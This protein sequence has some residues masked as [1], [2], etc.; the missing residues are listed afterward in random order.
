VGHLMGLPVFTDANIPT[1]LGAGTNE[2]RIIVFA[3][4]V[5]HLWERDGDPVTLSFEQLAG[6]SLQVQLVCYGY[7]AFPAGR[8]RAAAGGVSAVTAPTLYP[9][10][11]VAGCARGAPP[12]HRRPREGA[13]AVRL[14][15]HH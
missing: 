13:H 1:T 8:C 5:S 14:R 3:S 2:D 10:K 4:G 15:H 6:T 11:S 7:A 9:A 12:P